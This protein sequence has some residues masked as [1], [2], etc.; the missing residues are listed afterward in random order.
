MLK[1]LFKVKRQFS[2][3]LTL[4]ARHFFLL[5]YTILYG[6]RFKVGHAI[7]FGTHF[8]VYFDA[9]QSQIELGNNVVFRDFCQLRSGTNGKLTIGNNVFFNNF[10]SIHSFYN[11]QIGNNNQFGEGV[12]MYDVNHRY[13]EQ[14]KLISEQ[15]YS[16]GNIII[17][18]NCW[19]GSNV[20]ILKGVTI[21]DNVVIGAGC[22]IHKSISSDSVVIQHQRLEIKK[23]INFSK[24]NSL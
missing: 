12:E 21:G 8:L 1:I 22:L 20:T 3:K 24:E 11:I 2:A 5:E 17:G 7:H 18:D 13:K 19:I 23:R 14:S 4:L 15:G 9:T 10:C 6:T 16:G